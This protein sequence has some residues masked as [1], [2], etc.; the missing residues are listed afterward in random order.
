MK[1]KIL[2]ISNELEAD[3]NA[4]DRFIHLTFTQTWQPIE[5]YSQVSPSHQ[6]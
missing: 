1:R 4:F 5:T 3:L 2:L 6:M